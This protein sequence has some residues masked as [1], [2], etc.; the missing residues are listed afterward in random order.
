MSACRTCS[1]PIRFVKM[2]TG[3][4]MPVDPVPDNLGNVVALRDQ[5]GRL[6][7]GHI[8]PP[9][10]PT[11]DGYTRLMPHY[12]TCAKTPARKKPRTPGPPVAAEPALF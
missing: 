3:S 4:S 8:V 2:R 12:G 6:T 9:D 7:D 5:I 10:Q 11:P 1:F